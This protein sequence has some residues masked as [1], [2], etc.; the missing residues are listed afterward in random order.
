LPSVAIGVFDV[1][2]AIRTGIFVSAHTQQLPQTPP[3]GVIL[4]TVRRYLTEKV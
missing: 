2:A 4:R 3:S 1:L